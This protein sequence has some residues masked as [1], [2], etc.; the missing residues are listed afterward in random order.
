MSATFASVADMPA[1]VAV[2][3]KILPNKMTETPRLKTAQELGV[4]PHVRRNV[5]V[6]AWYVH[7]SV[8]PEHFNIK[9]FHNRAAW[10][11]V[12]AIYDCTT[13][14]CFLGWAPAAGIKPKCD[15]DA[16]EWETWFDY[17]AHNFGHIGLYDLLFAP[18]HAN[19]LEAAVRRAA[20]FLEHG[21]PDLPPY[22][23]IFIDKSLLR[24]WEAPEDFEPKWDLIAQI[25]EEEAMTN[26]V[27]G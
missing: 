8:D 12:C 21:M 4:P 26:M 24:K 22:R 15:D 20:W 19:S 2:A 1:V 16:D 6:L 17:S 11:P 10:Y 14:A 25:A 3:A 27:N 5:A 13:A 18:E 7:R 9:G 23:R